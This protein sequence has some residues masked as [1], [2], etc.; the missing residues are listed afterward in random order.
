MKRIAAVLTL[1]TTA[2]IATATAALADNYPPVVEGGGGAAGGG[3][4][5]FTGGDVTGALVAIAVL[6][7]VGFV[8]LTV[9]RRR[10]A[11]VA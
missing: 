9:A 2:V 7:V 1:A 3:G 6:I 5:A 10:A 4:T 8:A 11:R